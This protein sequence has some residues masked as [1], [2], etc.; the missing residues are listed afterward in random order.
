MKFFLEYIVPLLLP[1]VVYLLWLRFAAA[2]GVERDMPWTWLAA[3][4][5]VL[6]AIVLGG[7]AL[8]GGSDQ[9]AYVPPHME[10]GKIVPGYFLPRH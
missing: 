3:A 8:F 7:L 9:G 5:V 4:G 6:V 2:D 1:T 10:N